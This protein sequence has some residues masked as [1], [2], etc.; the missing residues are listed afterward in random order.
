M[1]ALRQYP[2][3]TNNYQISSYD[4]RLSDLN[5]TKLSRRRIN[6]ALLFLYNLITDQIHCPFVKGLFYII[7][8]VYKYISGHRKK[9]KI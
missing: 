7:K 9:R 8:V 4:D 2:N 3:T 1:F 5:M 6:F